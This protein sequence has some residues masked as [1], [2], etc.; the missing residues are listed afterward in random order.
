MTEACH[1]DVAT[2]CMAGQ[3]QR[4]Q[5]CLQLYRLHGGCGCTQFMQHTASIPTLEYAGTPAPCPLP[6]VHAVRC[7]LQA[8]A[9][10]EDDEEDFDLG[11]EDAE[12]LGEED[13]EDYE[14]SDEDEEFLEEIE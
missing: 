7:R 3:A 9:L 13:D 14:L 8:G 1:A 4:T 6:C 5:L 12:G 10:S 11:D 2:A